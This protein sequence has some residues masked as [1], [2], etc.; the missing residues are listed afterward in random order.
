MADTERDR[1]TNT[2]HF[3]MFS[4]KTSNTSKVLLFI[5]WSEAEK[6]T[7]FGFSSGKYLERFYYFHFFITNRIK[8]NQKFELQHI[9]DK[10]FFVL[11]TI[12]WVIFIT[13][14]RRLK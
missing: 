8:K 10:L 6:E 4:E 12:F 2:V 13:V 9:S 5:L 7:R 1:K 14:C 3:K 11:A